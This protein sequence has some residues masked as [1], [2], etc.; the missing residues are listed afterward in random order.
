MDK[1]C[2]E[3]CVSWI[4]LQGGLQY[5]GHNLWV[6]VPPAPDHHIIHA[7]IPIGKPDYIYFPKL[8]T[9]PTIALAGKRETLH[10]TRIA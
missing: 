1:H 8:V 5:Q 10:K 9:R 7:P 2:G 3:G 4:S 6:G